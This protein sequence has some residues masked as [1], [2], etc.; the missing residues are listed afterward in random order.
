M[1]LLH[2]PLESW[3]VTSIQLRLKTYPQ[4][5]PLRH[6]SPRLLPYAFLSPMS[7]AR[8]NIKL[9]MTSI[10]NSVAAYLG[11]HYYNRVYS[12]YITS[13]SSLDGI[14]HT[15]LC[16]G[17]LSSP[18]NFSQCVFTYFYF[19][20]ISGSS[21]FLTGLEPVISRL[22]PGAMTATTRGKVNTLMS[23]NFQ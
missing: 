18:S 16:P 8:R 23:K 9:S 3:V 21:V 6:V 15:D 4:C 13:G 19:N 10:V 12:N 11:L 22:P 1:F 20:R 14:P 17:P 5:V 2:T 7:I